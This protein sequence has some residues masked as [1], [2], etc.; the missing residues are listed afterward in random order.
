[1]KQ[2]STMTRRMAEDQEYA[3][4]S[5]HLDRIERVKDIVVYFHGSALNVKPVLQILE[6]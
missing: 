5:K 2:A 1:M 3:A 4:I 6:R